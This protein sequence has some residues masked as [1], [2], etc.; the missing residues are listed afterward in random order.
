M[1]SDA[2]VARI[3]NLL[4]SS[5]SSGAE[6]LPPKPPPPI[7]DHEVVA[8]IGAVPEDTLSGTNA[9]AAY[10]FSTN[11]TLL[12]IFKNPTPARA[13]FFGGSVCAVGN[14]RVLI[15]AQGDD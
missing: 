13:D 5:Q 6:N 11:G 14:D 12:T 7:P 9:G 10:L 4:A 1:N 15:G 2:L 3:E 8:R